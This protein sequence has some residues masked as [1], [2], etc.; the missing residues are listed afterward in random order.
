MHQYLAHLSGSSLCIVNVQ[1]SYGG[2]NWIYGLHLGREM[3][4]GEDTYFCFMSDEMRRCL[5]LQPLGQHLV[6]EFC[7][8]PECVGSWNPQL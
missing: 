5:P 3:Q 4:Q 7:V 1:V 6:H 2:D 8:V